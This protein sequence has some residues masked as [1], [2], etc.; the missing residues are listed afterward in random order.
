MTENHF[1]CTNC[2]ALSSG[3]FCSACGQKKFERG[4][5]ALRHAI[6]EF[7]SEFSDLESSLGKT[8]RTLVLQP[9]KLTS[10]YLQGKQK[11]YVTPVKLYLIVITAN[12]LFYAFLEEYS[13]LNINMLKD[14]ADSITWFQRA[15]AQAQLASG[16]STNEFFHLV[17]S[18]VNDTLPIFLYFLIFA[19]ALVLKIQFAKHQRYY[20]EH[21]VFAL[22]FMSFGFLRDMALLPVQFLFNK[23]IALIIS[24]ATT[25]WY[26]SRSFKH[27]YA[28]QSK[29]LAFHTLLHYLIFFLL[30]T[31]VIVLAIMI[32][33]R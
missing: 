3:D 10:D 28:I 9:G 33:L 8:I 12:F 6:K 19:Q 26:L 2:S 24:I 11:S 22:H 13:F 27:A 14:M 29:R 16:F 15:I 1:T 32:A 23:Q 31:L 20:I 25:I 7:F 5:F 21:L 4:Q 30:F 17:N 18:R